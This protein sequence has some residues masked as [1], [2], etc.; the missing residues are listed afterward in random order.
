MDFIPD[1]TNYASIWVWLGV[2]TVF[3]VGFAIVRQRSKD[4]L[5]ALQMGLALA[6]I[7]AYIITLGVFVWNLSQ[8]AVK[9]ESIAVELE[10]TYSVFAS[11][12]EIRKLEYPAE[13]P[14]GGFKEYGSFQ[15]DNGD[16]AVLVWTGGELQLGTMEN[17]RFVEFERVDG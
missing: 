3:G 9:R 4:K 1:T 16:E 2:S 10:E 11:E 8:E 17:G 13:Q 7:L 14:V 12:R 5:V 15:R 6:G